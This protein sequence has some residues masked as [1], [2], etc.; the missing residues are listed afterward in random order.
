MPTNPARGGIHREFI[1]DDHAL[2]DTL[3]SFG[4]RSPVSLAIEVGFTEVSPPSTL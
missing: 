1:L 3:F 4:K 2:D